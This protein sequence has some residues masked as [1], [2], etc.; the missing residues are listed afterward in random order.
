MNMGVFAGGKVTR[1]TTEGV[2]LV[3][4]KGLKYTF[5]A[6]GECRNLT[7]TL[8]LM[9]QHCQ[10]C[11]EHC[12]A[13]EQTLSR[14]QG[15]NFPI[16]VGRRPSALSATCGKENIS[17]SAKPSFASGSSLGKQKATVVPGVG[18]AIQLANGEL[19]VQYHD[20]AQL[21]V[22]GKHHVRYQY[23]DGQVVNYRDTDSIPKSIMAKMQLMP[24]VVRHLSAPVPTRQFH[25]L[26]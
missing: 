13:L 24:K 17:R 5:P 18:T 6:A 21:W 1:S 19:Q 8:E 23:P 12:L 4:A 7:G 3:D 26:R 20:G 14:L 22:D 16:I 9:W 10:E 15:T 2:S 11:F 25:N